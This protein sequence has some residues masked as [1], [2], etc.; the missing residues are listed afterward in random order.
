MNIQGW[1]PLELTGLIS[2]DCK[3][4]VTNP[5]F[6]LVV[7]LLSSFPKQTKYFIYLNIIS[8]SFSK[9]VFLN[10]FPINNGIFF[11]C[12]LCVKLKLQYFDRPVWRD[13]SLEKT[14]MMKDWRQKE[15]GAAENGMVI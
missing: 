1:F 3:E 5:D 10:F 14:L 11:Y 13:I 6:N 15:K 2:L 8:F 4:I 12:V 7:N 9:N